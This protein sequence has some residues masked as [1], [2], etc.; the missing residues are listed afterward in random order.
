MLLR[1]RQSGELVAGKFI[2]RGGM[3]RC[4][5]PLRSLM[6]VLPLD[7]VRASRIP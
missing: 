5:V 4:V 1:N 2:Q 7:S 6:R 3:V